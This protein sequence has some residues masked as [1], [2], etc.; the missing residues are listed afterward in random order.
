MFSLCISRSPLRWPCPRLLFMTFRCT[1]AR[2]I[3]VC[4]KGMRFQYFLIMSFNCCK[5]VKEDYHLKIICPCNDIILECDPSFKIFFFIVCHRFFGATFSSSTSQ[6][7]QHVT[8]LQQHPETSLHSQ[9]YQKQPLPLSMA[10]FALH[11][12]M[13]YHL[14]VFFLFFI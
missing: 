10:D 9:K 6:S 14:I 4:C 1:H 7:M 5:E 12:A 11:H 13:N 3:F 8:T 2:F